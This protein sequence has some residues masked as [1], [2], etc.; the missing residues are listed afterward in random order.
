M[1]TAHSKDIWRSLKRGK[2]RFISILLITA[3]GVTMLTGLTAACKDLRASADSFFDGQGLFD[4]SIMSTLGL[5][6]ED[7]TALQALDGVAAAEGAYSETVYTAVD[8]RRMSVEM[9]TISAAGINVPYLMEGTLPQ[10]ANEIAVTQKYLQNT[11]KRV[12]ASV[13]IEENLTTAQ[14]SEEDALLEP[15]AETPSF[16]NTTYTISGVVIDPTNVNSPDG[17]VAFRSAVASDY[18]FFVLPAAVNSD[19][20]TAVYLTVTDAAPM[21]CYSPEYEALVRNMTEKIERQVKTQREIARY[22][23]V[24]AEAEEKLADARQEIDEKFA[25][26]D[27][28]F[29]KAEQELADG[30]VELNDGLRTL[31]EEEQKANQALA[32]AH[33]QINSGYAEMASGAAQLDAAE[34]QLA[35]GENQLAQGRQTLEA[36]QRDAQAQL[37]A[38]RTQLTAAQATAQGTH[39]NLTQQAAPIVDA[40]SGATKS[41]WNTVLT[42]LQAIFA[43]A[44]ALQMQLQQMQGQLALLTPGTPEYTELEAQ[45]TALTAQHTQAQSDA[46]TAAEGV[47]GAFFTENFTENSSLDANALRTLA[48][49]LGQTGATLALLGEQLA[50]LD[51]QQAAA[52]AQFDA[53][54]RE[55]EANA[56]KL[57]EGRAQLA[58]GRAELESGSAQLAEGAAELVRQ[59]EEARQKLT[60]ARQELA[61]GTRELTDGEQELLDNKAEVEEKRAEALQKLEDAR[62]ELTDIDMTQWYVQDR[63]TLSGYVNVESDAASIEAVG[64]AFP[65][66]FFIVAILISLTTITRMVEEERGVIGTYK[67]LG[68]SNGEI[69]RKYLLY[70]GA[71]CVL[72]GLLGDFCGFVVLPK[73]VFS[74]FSVMYV[75][76]T[77]TL[78]FDL[79]YG[80]GGAMLFVAGIVGA[81]VLACRAEL[82]QTPAALMRPKA[83]RVGTRVF[84]ERITPLW[85]RLSFLNKVTAR[86][87]FRYKKRLF[88]TVAGIMGC[89]ALV[90]CAFAIKDSVSDLMPRQYEQVYQYDILAATVGEDNDALLALLDG[91]AEVERYLNTQ[92][93]NVKLKTATGEEK[94]QMIVVPQGASL[95]GYIQLLDLSG[96]PVQLADGGIYVTRNAATVLDFAQGDTVALQNLSLDEHTVTV[97]SLVENYL[98]NMVYMTQATYEEMFG[99]FEPNGALIALSAQCTDEPAFADTL[100]RN[101]AVLSAV[102]TQELRADFS[103]AFALINMVVYII[104]FM[105]AGLAFV[106][107]FTLSTTNISERE[108]ELATIKVLG[109]FDGEV[110]SYVNKETLLL[111]ALGIL[112]GLPLGH[113]LGSALSLVLQ[114]PS[115]YFAVSIFPISYVLA[116]AIS[117]CFALLVDL[118]TNRVLDRIN[119]VEALKSIE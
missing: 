85:K 69:R 87:L 40:M 82:R 110:H 89:T 59:E 64:T 6:D 112:C 101:E 67:A 66:V 1:R 73:I 7:V 38:A 72:G 83:P 45:C 119:P 2:K 28:E 75:L 98:G 43:S 114:L 27:E 55:I 18:T 106:V 17:A 47:Y 96:A 39:D 86:N 70:A 37:D 3:L 76:P 92:L 68:F 46:N 4:V 42:D 11:G 88:M 71:A 36:A 9:K 84:L 57:A 12:G 111:T 5:T 80:L 51:A 99:A 53:A 108:R 60:D 20:Y 31:A 14:D 107:L 49:E 8:G 21:L 118:L 13:V 54:W 105:A 116:A 26:A 30:R 41:A 117:F 74:I 32:D 113:A 22:N 63:G 29:A 50:Q 115:I 91:N 109:F 104:L 58:A 35:D 78:Q 103:T 52:Q 56:A 33:A 93:E 94:V 81:T 34:K 61:D 15:A 65:I 90:L 19:V 10:T 97:T 95:D 77:Y 48:M 62:D 102:S 100:S 79:A 23:A 24:I 25:E 16:P 44:C